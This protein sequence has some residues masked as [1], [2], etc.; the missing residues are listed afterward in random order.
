MYGVRLLFGAT[1]AGAYPTISK[2]TKAWFPLS[3][4][5]SLQGWIA[6]F[7]GRSGGA[8]ANLLFTT[9]M[10]GLVGLPWRT[11]IFILAV[12]GVA[13]GVAV[14]S[15]LRD[16]PR[17]DSRVN[18]AEL[19]L[20]GGEPAVPA[21][22]TDA[23]SSS[24]PC[25]LPPGE[26][27]FWRRISG[28]S[29][30]NM[31]YFLTQGFAATFADAVYVNW[32]PYFLSQERG[33]DDTSMGILSSLPLWGGACGGVVG[34]YC[35]DFLLRTMPSRRWARSLVGATGMG[36]ACVLVF[37]ALLAYENP[38]L[39]CAVLACSKFFSDWSQPTVWGTVTDIAGRHTATVFGLVN[40]VGGVGALVAP[41]ALGA[42]AQYRSWNAAFALIAVIYALGA[43][44]WLLVNCTV[45]LVDER[46]G[47]RL[48]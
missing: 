27:S 40:G 43:A 30:R 15:V 47:R 22:A 32:L 18:D 6:S 14:L 29:A 44:A 9:V 31:G 33:L 3:I 46:V 23:A 2:V 34:G 28:R 4:R 45:P 1:Q 48:P 16:T 5:T 20:I 41:A 21:Q 10:L 26:R 39:F 7:F 38:Y 17:Q 19:S 13:L 35:N 42:I 8:S 24:S 36:M 25:P 11:A 37:V 12:A